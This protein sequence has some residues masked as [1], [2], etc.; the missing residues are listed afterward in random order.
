ML[1]SSLPLT[2]SPL[3]P[4]LEGADLFF[5]VA[6]SFLAGSFSHKAVFGGRLCGNRRRLVSR[7]IQTVYGPIQNIYS[8]DSLLSA[9][10]LSHP[11]TGSSYSYTRRGRGLQSRLGIFFSRLQR[12]LQELVGLGATLSLRRMISLFEEGAEVVLAAVVVV[13]WRRMMLLPPFLLLW[14]PAS[15]LPPSYCQLSSSALRFSLSSLSSMNVSR[16]L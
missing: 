8:K 3:L 14:P 12:D 6:D 13:D 15:F 16:S 7:R 9:R 10:P 11:R 1:L 5:A 4:L 2:L